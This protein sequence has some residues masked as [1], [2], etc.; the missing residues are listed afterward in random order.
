MFSVLKS[1]E[2][3]IFCFIEKTR[4]LVFPSKIME[5]GKIK[6][7]QKCLCYSIPIYYCLLIVISKQK[8]NMN[9]V[10]YPSV[11]EKKKDF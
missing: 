6:N 9:L 2:M 11:L 1:I 8:F 5:I 3:N 10:F 7:I 4:S